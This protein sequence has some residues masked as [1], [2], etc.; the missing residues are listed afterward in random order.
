MQVRP[1]MPV[2]PPKYRF[3]PNKRVQVKTEKSR[4]PVKTNRAGAP[5]SIIACPHREL[6]YAP[7]HIVQIRD[8]YGSRIRPLSRYRVIALSTCAQR[9]NATTR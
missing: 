7:S 9:D 5:I 6:T 8:F 2:R 4:T 1:K 3:T